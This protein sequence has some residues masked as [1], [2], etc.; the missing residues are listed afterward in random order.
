MQATVSEGL[1]Y[2][3]VF[4][5]IKIGPRDWNWFFLTPNHHIS[6]LEFYKIFNIF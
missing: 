5:D 4:D 3:I 6:V 1:S 2:T